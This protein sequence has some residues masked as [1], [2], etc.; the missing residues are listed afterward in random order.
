MNEVK[1]NATVSFFA[2]RIAHFKALAHSLSRD[3]REDEAVFAKVQM[4]IYDIF[5]TIFS[6]AVKTSGQDDDKVVQFFMTKI[7]QIP[8]SWLTAMDRAEQHGESEK[9]HMERIKLEAVAEIK[10]EFKRIWEIRI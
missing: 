8:Q 10:K 9:A 6:V 4:N 2:D 5:S 1:Q 3:D 7:Q